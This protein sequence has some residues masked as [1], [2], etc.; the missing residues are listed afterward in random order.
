MRFMGMAEYY[1]KFC[2]NFSSVAAPLT[3]LLKK[4]QNLFGVKNAKL[5][6]KE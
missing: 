3:A 1:R 5:H 4:K 6:S 2:P